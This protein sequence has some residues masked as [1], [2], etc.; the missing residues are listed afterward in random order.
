MIP[1]AGAVELRA[2][3]RDD[4][5]ALA[6]I[7]GAHVAS[8]TGSFELT[9]PDAAD[10]R[11]RF[12]AIT[13]EGYPWLVAC[14]RG[15]VVGYAYAAAYRPRPAYRY[16]VEDSVYLASAAQR[17]GIGR[18]LLDRLIDICTARG[19]RQMV[20]VIGDAANTASIALHAR[21]G[22]ADA[23]RLR[24]VGRKFDRWLDVVLMQRALGSGAGSAPDRP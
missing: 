15:D 18:A 4:A 6:A 20:A 17:R 2:A 14:E 5:P 11:R 8:G 7:Y 10:M 21:A 16:T 9:P 13:D 23:G 24:D 3:T 22:F 1:G 19:D 12:V